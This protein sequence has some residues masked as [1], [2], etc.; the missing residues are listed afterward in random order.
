MPAPEISLDDNPFTRENMFGTSVPEKAPVL[1]GEAA[2]EKTSAETQAVLENL[3]LKGEDP[4]KRFPAEKGWVGQ[5]D[6]FDYETEKGFSP[7]V[8]EFVRQYYGPAEIQTRDPKDISAAEGNVVT[9]FFRRV[10]GSMPTEEERAQIA[11]AKTLYERG[12]QDSSTRHKQAIQELLKGRPSAADMA[13]R[14]PEEVPPWLEKFASQRQ[15]AQ[16]PKTQAKVLAEDYA[17]K[18][19]TDTDNKTIARGRN[20]SVWA[21]Q[22]EGITPGLAQQS[23]GPILA[24]DFNERL[25]LEG[26]PEIS[27]EELDIKQTIFQGDKLLTFVHPVTK[28]RTLLDPVKLEWKDFAEILPE[29]MVVGGDIAGMAAGSLGYLAGPKTGVAGNII[30]GALG[31]WTGRMSSIR[32]ALEKHGFAYNDRY[33]GFTK[34]GF[35]E[36]DKNKVTVGEPHVIKWEDIAFNAK[37]DA[38]WSAVGNIGVRLAFKLGKSILTR[39]APALKGQLTEEQF[40]R[41][42]ENWRKSRLGTDLAE[43]GQQGPLSVRLEAE[44]ARLQTASR[45]ATGPEA[46]ALK[47]EADQFYRQASVIRHMEQGTAA[48]GDVELA[49]ETLLRKGVEGEGD[50][51][52]AQVSEATSTDVA[53]AVQKGLP[54]TGMLELDKSIDDLIS[55]NNKIIEEFSVLTAKG[56]PEAAIEAGKSFADKAQ[57]IMGTPTGR[58]GVYGGW[59]KLGDALNR[60]GQAGVPTKPFDLSSAVALV[61]K[62]QKGSGAIGGPIGK[63]VGEWNKAIGRVAGVKDA[64]QIPPG[65]PINVGYNQLKDLLLSMRGEIGS[66]SLNQPQIKNLSNLIDEI[67]KIQLRGV[68][69]VDD[70]LGTTYASKLEAL[71]NNFKHLTGTWQR[72]LTQSLEEGT[73]GSLVKNIFKNADSDFV[74]SVIKNMKP[75]KE[76]LELLKN[77]ML[78]NYKEALRGLARGET[79]AAVDVGGKRVTIGVEK[80]GITVTPASEAAHRKFISENG[81]WI[82][83]LFKDGEFDEL[84]EVM[85]RG[86]TTAK[87]LKNLQK[88]DETLRKHPLFQGSGGMIEINQNLGTVVVREPQL[89]VDEIFNLKPGD[90]SRGMQALYS[91]INIL[92]KAERYIAKENMRALSIRRMFNPEPA[93]VAISREAPENTAFKSATA[94]LEEIKHNESLYNIVFGQGPRKNLEK[95]FKD[96]ELV[97]RETMPTVIQEAAKGGAWRGAKSIPLRAAKVWVGVL[98]RRARTLTQTKEAFGEGLEN[99][100]QDILRNPDKAAQMVALSKTN[101]STKFGLNAFGQLMGLNEADTRRAVADFGEIPVEEIALEQMKR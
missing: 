46:L 61:N 43:S 87:E 72:G 18:Q 4:R 38:L 48:Q 69:E 59:N 94:A 53:R 65:T 9:D 47:E 84:A 29:A 20:A 90:R 81:A 35:V 15:K 54:K 19:P 23:V 30:G 100:I 96:L 86:A 58:T 55:R 77:A 5:E 64:S 44:A 101:L 39:G 67:E 76:Q 56:T 33:D 85:T 6:V 22:L 34:E 13:G 42:A 60:R 80:E 51:T 32:T 3:M 92:P 2:Q 73:F 91:A 71:N 95:I 24:A 10:F 45:E 25:K 11:Q 98:N 52:L 89:L 27:P 74:G 70:I 17:L 49:K 63:I 14:V 83:A 12:G 62:L 75:G 21:N 97:S 68:Q 78:H 57:A 31:A 93:G 50:V 40:V 1:T 41:A 37:D 8:R 79:E 82:K 88:F 16:L 7:R 28:D 26:K 36:T 66:G 99:R